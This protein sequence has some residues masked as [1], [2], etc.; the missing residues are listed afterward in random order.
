MVLL[1][2]DNLDENTRSALALRNLGDPLLINIDRS[3]APA[4]GETVTEAF[5]LLIVMF[6]GMRK[7]FE[8]YHAP[9]SAIRVSGSGTTRRIVCACVKKVDSQVHVIKLRAR[10][11]VTE[12]Y[13]R[14]TIGDIDDK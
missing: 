2:C 8:R 3:D 10:C 12:N 7:A 4:S 11:V 13:H 9:G 6:E 1:F 5:S 14:T